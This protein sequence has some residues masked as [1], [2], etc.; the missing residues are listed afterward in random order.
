VNVTVDPISTFR[1]ELQAAARRRISA[2]R[3]RVAA[4][5]AALAA[6]ALVSGLSIAGTGWLTGE[7]APKPVVQDFKAYTPQLGF[8]PEPGKAVFVAE[9]GAVS[10]YATTNREGTYCIV[11]DDPW[12]PATAGDGGSCVSKAS[13]AK[14]IAAW[15]VGISAASK[16]AEATFVVAGRVARQEARTI[17]FRDPNGTLIERPIGATGFFVAALRGKVPIPVV[18]PNGVTCPNNG[19]KPTFVALAS[20][21]EPLLEST[22]PLMASRM[23]TS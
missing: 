22:I 15:F 7:P 19:W 23:C 14:P 11:V 21:G 20:E 3:R 18:T 6:G 12:K 13:A 8:H 1:L 10:L 4:F 5:A 16:D 17:R 9:D 2:R